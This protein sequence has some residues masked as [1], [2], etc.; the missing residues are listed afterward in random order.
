VHQ[1]TYYLLVGLFV[2]ECLFLPIAMRRLRAQEQRALREGTLVEDPGSFY[3][4]RNNMKY[5]ERVLFLYS[6]KSIK[7]REL[8]KAIYTA[9]A[10]WIAGWTTIIVLFA[11]KAHWRV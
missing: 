1:L 10:A 9:R 8:L 11:A 4:L 6:N 5:M 3:D 7:D 2:A